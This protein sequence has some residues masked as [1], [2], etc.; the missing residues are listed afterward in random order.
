MTIQ[1]MHKQSAKL[2][3]KGKGPCLD[4]SN[5]SGAEP[6]KSTPTESKDPETLASGSEGGVI[7]YHVLRGLSVKR[8]WDTE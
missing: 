1:A 7:R 8:Y 3:L 4:I 5:T 2:E 6:G